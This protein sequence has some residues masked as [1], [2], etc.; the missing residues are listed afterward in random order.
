MQQNHY[1]YDCFSLVFL[2]FFCRFCRFTLAFPPYLQCFPCSCR[3]SGETLLVPHRKSHSVPHAGSFTPH[4]KQTNGWSDFPIAME[5]NV[6]PVW[7]LRNFQRN[8]ADRLRSTQTYIKTK[9]SHLFD[10]T[11]E[12]V[13]LFLLFLNFSNLLEQ[14]CWEPVRFLHRF[15]TLIHI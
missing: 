2:Q 8:W 14:R 11:T 5:T 13:E 3:I 4:K 10:F 7:T 1:L 9:K 6:L 15:I 12:K